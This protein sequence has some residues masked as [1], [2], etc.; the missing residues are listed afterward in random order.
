M[1]AL[2]PQECSIRDVSSNPMLFC[3]G[4]VNNIITISQIS[5]V[6]YYEWGEPLV[7]TITNNDQ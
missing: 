5:S 1:T 2:S 3:I 7:F 4:V 6:Q